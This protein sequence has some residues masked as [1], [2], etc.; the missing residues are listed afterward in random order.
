MCLL[1]PF[2]FQNT[3]WVPVPARSVMLD[4]PKLEEIYLYYSFTTWRSSAYPQTNAV[5]SIPSHYTHHLSL[6]TAPSHH[7]PTTH[8]HTPHYTHTHIPLPDMQITTCLTYKESCLAFRDCSFFV[9]IKI[10]YCIFYAVTLPSPLTTRSS[11]I[12]RNKRAP[13]VIVQWQ[14]GNICTLPNV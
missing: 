3:V 1:K 9:V 12:S 4:L 13:L 6:F 7:H 11:C 5:T 8:T 10:G 14:E 2:A